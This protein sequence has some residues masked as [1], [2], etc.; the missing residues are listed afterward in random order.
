MDFCDYYTYKH[1][2]IVVCKLGSGKTH[3]MEGPPEDRGVT[4]RAIETL[5]QISRTQPEMK[6]E[7]TLSM[8]E[9]YNEKIL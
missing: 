7:V 1:M 2:I 8:L 4:F 3:T 9:V 6:T 5:F